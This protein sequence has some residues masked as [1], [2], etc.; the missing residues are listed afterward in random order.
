M[1]NR[2][3]LELYIFTDSSFYSFVL[4]PMHTCSIV[5]QVCTEF[6]RSGCL[7]FSWQELGVQ[8]VLLGIAIPIDHGTRHA[9]CRI[10]LVTSC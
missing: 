5:S 3:A 7:T 10:S 2:L 8:Y 4:I 9:I 6:L 1:D